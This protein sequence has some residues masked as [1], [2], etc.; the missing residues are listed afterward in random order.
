MVVSR[1]AGHEHVQ[2]RQKEHSEQQIHDQSADDHDGKR[3]LRVQPVLLNC[4]FARALRILI[5]RPKL[6]S[7]FFV[8]F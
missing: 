3:P 4:L 1:I 2:V 6:L 8:L 7:E 5:A